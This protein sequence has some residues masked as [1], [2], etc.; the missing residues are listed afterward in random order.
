MPLHRLQSLRHTPAPRLTGP[1][2][3][4]L[5]RPGGQTGYSSPMVRLLRC[6]DY[7]RAAA[8][9]RGAPRPATEPQPAP[10]L[11]RD[12][13]T[14]Q[15]RRAP[16]RRAGRGGLATYLPGHQPERPEL[17]RQCHRVGAGTAGE[18]VEGGEPHATGGP[19]AGHLARGP[20][21]PTRRGQQRDH[22]GP[23]EQLQLQP[24]GENAHPVSLGEASRVVGL[25]TTCGPAALQA[26]NQFWPAAPG[27]RPA[28]ARHPLPPLLRAA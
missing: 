28:P 23:H 24:Q 2:L 9:P 10:R 22:P 16:R 8:L 1:H 20:C 3:P 13:T 5:T 19:P 7:L 11:T 21:L 12:P 27:P 17:T 4:P 6:G 25:H 14:P 26:A 18:P 15:R